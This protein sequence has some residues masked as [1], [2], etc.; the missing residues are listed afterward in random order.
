MTVLLSAQGSD[1]GRW[2]RPSSPRP[3]PRSCYR[4][5]RWQLS[6]SPIRF[7]RDKLA[8][9]EW[10]RHGSNLPT[11]IQQQYQ[12]RSRKN[13][14]KQESFET[15]A[16][17]PLETRPCSRG[18]HTGW[19]RDA[20]KSGEF[21]GSALGVRTCLDF[22]KEPEDEISNRRDCIRARR[23]GD[24]AAVRASTAGERYHCLLR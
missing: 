13:A 15:S 17:D 8:R 7:L 23:H 6:E 2:L 24:A 21:G 12:P 16:R 4:L 11:Y 14:S 1:C 18:S 5:E 19:H 20:P 3:E 10:E 22:R 9:D